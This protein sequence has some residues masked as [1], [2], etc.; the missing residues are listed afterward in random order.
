MFNNSNLLTITV[1]KISGGTRQKPAEQVFTDWK[2]FWE[3][4]K[5]CKIEEDY[6]L[7]ISNFSWS[8]NKGLTKQVAAAKNF[9][10]W[11]VDLYER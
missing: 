4:I 6:T 5:D 8:I 7:V 9:G 1:W 3:Y 10:F 11:H 2:V